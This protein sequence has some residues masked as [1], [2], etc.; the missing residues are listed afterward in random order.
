MRAI[1]NKIA[2]T[3]RTKRNKNKKSNN[4]NKKQKIAEHLIL[5]VWQ[6]L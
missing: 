4:K 2:M 3:S 6:Y 5:L 1:N